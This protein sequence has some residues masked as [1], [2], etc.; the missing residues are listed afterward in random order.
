MGSKFFEFTRT[1]KE[2]RVCMSRLVVSEVMACRSSQ[3][4]IGTDAARLRISRSSTAP[5]ITNK[6]RRQ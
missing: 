5:V 4:G 2:A 1:I 3:T 6:Q